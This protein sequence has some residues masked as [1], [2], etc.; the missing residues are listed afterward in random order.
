M[1][2]DSLF[3]QTEAHPLRL[4]FELTKE[5]LSWRRPLLRLQSSPFLVCQ[6][7][8]M[9]SFQLC[10]IPSFTYMMTLQNP[11]D[12]PESR[13]GLGDRVTL[14]TEN[15]RSTYEAKVVQVNMESFGKLPSIP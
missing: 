5:R 9:E 10:S 4:L 14:T 15:T 2:R 12:L 7:E 8:L 6:H 11:R 3:A 1:S 13:L